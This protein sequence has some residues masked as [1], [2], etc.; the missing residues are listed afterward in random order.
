MNSFIIRS[1]TIA[2]T[3]LIIAVLSVILISI[4]QFREIR[5]TNS[6]ITRNEENRYLMQQLLLS[7]LDNETGAR[8]YV[9]TGKEDFLEPLKKSELSL[10]KFRN[11]LSSKT[12]NPVLA[13]LLKDSLSPLIDKRIAFS[14]QMVS[15]RKE[16]KEDEVRMLVLG[17]KGKHYTDEF[18]R[19]SDKMN[20][21][22]SGILNK[23]RK[24]NEQSIYR[25]NL[26]LYITL[27]FIFILSVI[28]FRE[29]IRFSNKQKAVEAE[30][31]RSKE[32]FSTL[33]Y[34]SPVMKLIFEPSEIRILDVNDSFCNFFGFTKDELIGKTTAETG[35]RIPSPLREEVIRKMQA[36]ELVRNIEGQIKT[37]KGEQ[38]WVSI[39]L[40]RVSIQNNDRII[41]SYVDITQ[42]KTQQEII[43]NHNRELEERVFEKTRELVKNEEELRLLN[44]TLERKVLERTAQLEKANKEMEA[45]SYS[46]SHDLRAPLRGIIGFTNIIEEDYGSKMEEEE[47]RLF[48]IIKNNTQKMGSLID[49]LLAFS[50]LGRKEL[51]RTDVDMQTMVQEV[52]TEL[53]KNLTNNI[54]WLIN[55]LPP[56]VADY[57]TIKQVWSNLIG[58][59]IKYSSKNDHP[60]IE[61]G[62]FEKDNKQVYFIKDNGVGFDPRYKDKLFRVFQRL[63]SENEFEGTGIGLALSDKIITRHGGSIWAEGDINKGASF[64]FTLL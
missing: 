52:V 63:H 31:K 29:I 4:L 14:R 48:T 34:K 49:D 22:R 40:D 23:E 42:Q 24:N 25:L 17:G 41:G 7:M 33:F 51:T 13:S 58:N 47:K 62:S 44:E 26:F 9:I 11:E 21:I 35:L 46:V 56:A 55:P 53:D 54:E 5:E 12:I 2:V 38:K 8:G 64:Y 39:N 18:R 36:G 32:V 19:I 60:K 50:R 1:M 15:L 30:L 61:V 45:F 6:I 27:G 20:N 43:A 16:G 59:A 57:T 3:L 28:N 37:N 10:Q